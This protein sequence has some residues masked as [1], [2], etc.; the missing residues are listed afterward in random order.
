MKKIRNFFWIGASLLIATSALAKDVLVVGLQ[1]DAKSLD[2]AKT[3]EKTGIALVNQMYDQL[4]SMSEEQLTQAQPELAESWDISD[5]G[6]AWTFHLRKGVA[7]VSGHP[8]SAEDVAFSLRR[9]IALAGAPSG[10]LM[11]F[12]LT[13]DN[14][15]VVDDMTVR[16]TLDKPY[17]PGLFLACLASFVGSVIEKSAVM[18][19]E[20]HGDNGSAWLETHSAGTGKF[21]LAEQMADDSYVLK[22]NDSYWKTP[23]PLRQIIVKNIDDPIEQAM[24]LEKGEIDVAWNLHPDQ[25]RQIEANPNIESYQ[26]PTLVVAFAGM[27]LRYAPFQQ[28]DARD[29]LRYA[30]DYDGL[31]DL[32]LQGAAKK[33][34]TLIPQGLL[35]Y[36]P[37][38]PYTHDP[39]KAKEL[40]A[41]AGYPD[42][43]EVEL[44]CQQA[45]PWGEVALKLKSDLAESG[46]RV[47]IVSV[48]EPELW[49]HIFSRN[50]QLYL[51]SGEVDYLDP[52]SNAVVLAHCENA[53]EDAAVK[54]LAW[55]SSYVN[56]EM[57][58]LTDRAIVE[59][60]QDTR[61]ELYRQLTNIVLDDGPYAF[62]YT[63]IKSYAVR[64]DV[65][66]FLGVQSFL[67]TGFPPVR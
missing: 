50:F 17:A 57:S 52:N 29:A 19:H 42:G 9:V 25:L 2:P 48:T 61:A 8:V 33:I 24:L 38:M 54:F 67:L 40:L 46:I 30:I 36:N 15:S 59:T 28:S 4:V 45:A 26:A 7:F 43:F 14:I 11:P 63:P 13:Q 66:E 6:A 44:L 51:L 18:A 12:G 20:Q 34:Q 35:G 47:K 41:S 23:S 27:N 64:T 53:E 16:V 55:A 21:M 58:A 31:V 60:N 5:D 49:D 56:K 22:R 10:M 65:R 3:F 39:Q 32:V 37:D 62:L 1:N